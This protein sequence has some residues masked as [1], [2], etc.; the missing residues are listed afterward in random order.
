METVHLLEAAEFDV[1]TT[2]KSCPEQTFMKYLR[3]P[4]KDS[5]QRNLIDDIQGLRVLVSVTAILIFTLGALLGLGI[6]GVRLRHERPYSVSFC[7]CNSNG[8]AC[9]SK[10]KEL[11]HLQSQ[12]SA[13]RRYPSMRQTTTRT[14]GTQELHRLSKTG[15]GRTL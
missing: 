13:I 6:A 9:I 5:R 11:K 3:H 15:P 1:G 10:L 12:P 7:E 8:R 14:A 2:R 4:E